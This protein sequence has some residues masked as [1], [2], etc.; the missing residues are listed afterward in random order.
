M[1]LKSDQLELDFY[2]VYIKEQNIYNYVNKI[3]CHHG[4]KNGQSYGVFP[5]IFIR[6]KPPFLKTKITVH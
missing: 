6:G 4:E 3:E 5:H 2:L 1:S